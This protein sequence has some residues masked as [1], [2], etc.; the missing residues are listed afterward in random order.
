MPPGVLHADA[1]Q[2]H[3]RRG[4]ALAL[5]VEVRHD[6]LEAATGLVDDVRRRH[7]HVRERDERRPGGVH[8][9][10]V[11]APPRDARAGEW[12]DEQGDAACAWPAGADRR[13]DVRGP[14]AV[15]NPFLAAV[16]EVVGALEDGGSLDVGYV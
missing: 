10:V 6:D 8:A 16:D 4:H 7:E 5:G 11:H 9:R 14:E 13:G 12:D 3:A 15:G 1:A 2:A